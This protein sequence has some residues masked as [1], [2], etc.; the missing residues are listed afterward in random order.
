MWS[1]SARPWYTSDP[2]LP[3]W[4]KIITGKLLLLGWSE[5]GFIKVVF[6]LSCWVVLIFEVIIFSTVLSL[7]IS[8]IVTE[9]SEFKVWLIL[10]ASLIARIELPPNLKKSSLIPTLSIGNPNTSA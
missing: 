7:K 10:L 5:Y 2:P 8:A 1:L 6:S 9:I 4:I 3:G